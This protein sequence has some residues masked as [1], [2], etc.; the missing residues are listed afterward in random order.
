MLRLPE[1]TAPMTWPPTTSPDFTVTDWLT[2]DLLSPSWT[3]ELGPEFE[4]SLDETVVSPPLCCPTSPALELDARASPDEPLTSP[5][6][7]DAVTLESAQTAAAGPK[8]QVR[9]RIA[10]ARS[11]TFLFIVPLACPN[12]LLR[13]ANSTTDPLFQ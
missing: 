6:S 11:F 7:L 4:T 3:F 13:Q 9:A 1:D 12:G 8:A 10:A 2:S 5:E